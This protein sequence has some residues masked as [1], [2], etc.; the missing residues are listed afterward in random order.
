M[1]KSNEI[2][3]KV[4]KFGNGRMDQL[5]TL[6]QFLHKYQHYLGGKQHVESEPFHMIDYIYGLQDDGISDSSLI[7]TDGDCLLHSLLYALGKTTDTS[8]RDFEG[9]HTIRAKIVNHF[10]KLMGNQ[11]GLK[12]DSVPVKES[13]NSEEN[14]F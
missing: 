8:L 7:V 6:L 2:E 3:V 5:S 11:P 1:D 13:R 9:F 4:G 14:H 12:I 10:I